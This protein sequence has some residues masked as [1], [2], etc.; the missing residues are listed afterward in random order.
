[1]KIISSRSNQL[2]TLDELGLG[3]DGHFAE[4]KDFPADGLPSSPLDQIFFGEQ[5]QTEGEGHQED[6]FE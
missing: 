6:D 1:M 5:E 4:V 3:S 2:V